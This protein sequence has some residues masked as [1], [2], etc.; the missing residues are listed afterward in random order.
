[1]AQGTVVSGRPPI[2]TITRSGE[3]LARWNPRDGRF[4]L[5]KKAL[6]L[7]ESNDAM[8]RAH[9]ISNHKWVG[10][11]F[12]TNVEHFQG[13]IRVG[14]EI[15]VYQDEI[16]VGSARAVASQW[17]WPLGPGRLARTRHRL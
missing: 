15:L 7:L 1:M 5:S 12:P 9:L 11:L 6:P 10:D 13:E 8:P 3:Q 4:A 2:L 14:D 17:E 16:L